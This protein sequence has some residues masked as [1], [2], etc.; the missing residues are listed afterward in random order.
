MTTSKGKVGGLPAADPEPAGPGHQASSQKTGR[1][2]A[3]SPRLS[4]A[5]P[6]SGQRSRAV[7]PTNGLH[8]ARVSAVL[9]LLLSEGLAPRQP[10]SVQEGHRRVDCWAPGPLAT[11]LCHLHPPM[12]TPNFQGGCSTHTT[13]TVPNCLESHVFSCTC[14]PGRKGQD[15]AH[16]R[17]RELHHQS[18]LALHPKDHS[19]LLPAPTMGGPGSTSTGSFRFP[20]RMPRLW[21]CNAVFSP[22]EVMEMSGKP[23]PPALPVDQGTISAG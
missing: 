3:V 4:L 10:S 8:K 19:C 6:S 2:R 16:T 11:G 14:C 15:R 1:P 22:W 17:G 5:H 23:G 12:G 9:H 20:W 13:C 21:L 7:V 18:H